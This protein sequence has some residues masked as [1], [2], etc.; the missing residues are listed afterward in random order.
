[1]HR[2][3]VFQVLFFFSSAAGVLS[4]PLPGPLK[5]AFSRFTQDVVVIDDQ[6]YRQFSQNAVPKI[7]NGIGNL[8]RIAYQADPVAHKYLVGVKQ[9]AKTAGAFIAAQS[10]NMNNDAPQDFT[11][12]AEEH[13]DWTAFAAWVDDINWPALKLDEPDIQARLLEVAAWVKENPGKTAAVGVAVVGIAL[14]LA[15]GTVVG[16]ALSTIGFGVEGP[17]AGK[18]SPTDKHIMSLAFDCL[19]FI[20]FF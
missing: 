10:R 17:I 20:Q 5:S 2:S 3:T 7:N 16:P 11:R 18:H 9:H 6:V 12:W 14:V 1:M 8:E 15:P 13:I 4:N 19:Q